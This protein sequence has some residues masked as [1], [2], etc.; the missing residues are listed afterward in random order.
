MFTGIIT[1]IG[2]VQT[3]EPSSA[4][5]RLTIASGYDTEAIE[6]GASIACA[7]VCLTVVE[8]RSGWFGV[9][10]SRETLSVTTI[11]T[12]QEG[13]KVNLERALRI[14]EELGGH[15]VLGHVDGIGRVTEMAADGDNRRLTITLVPDQRDLAAY[16][17]PKGSICVDGVSLTVNGVSEPAADQ[18]S[19]CVNIIPHTLTHTSLGALTVGAMANLEVDL[20][21]RYAARLE[22][23]RGQRES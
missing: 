23:F 2:T 5:L 14:G 19:F 17:A 20:M 11:G 7:G 15:I 4:G 9:D 1:N 13:E 21:A 8:K 18:Q 16:L 22:A 12:W 3:A 10:V 6:L